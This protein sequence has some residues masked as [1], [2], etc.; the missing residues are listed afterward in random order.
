MRLVFAGH[1]PEW[2]QYGILIVI[3][4]A[5]YAIGYEV[6]K[7]AI[8]YLKERR[9]RLKRKDKIDLSGTWHVAW[10]SSVEGKENINTELLRIEQKAGYVRIENVEKSSENKLG[11]YLWRGEM[12]LY[13][14]EHLIGEYL[15]LDHNVVF[16]GVM[17][18]LM[19]RVGNFMI[20]KWVGCNYDYEFTWGFGVIAKDK[21]FALQKL[22]ELL[23]SKK[24]MVSTSRGKSS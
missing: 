10:Q 1:V 12:K 24:G 8:E 13:D 3:G 9:L 20:G 17:Y 16:K 11:G 22:Q 7:A 14:N 4:A 5:L 15:P 23:R 2:L 6:T 21:D 19:N 18:F